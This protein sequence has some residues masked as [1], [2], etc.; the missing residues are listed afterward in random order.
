MGAVVH[1]LAWTVAGGFGAQ[2]DRAPRMITA[3]VV[4]DAI[5][6]YES[7]PATGDR[8]GCAGARRHRA[9]QPH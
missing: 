8:E 2:L 3:V 6:A 5:H 1:A 4:V 7:R 9:N